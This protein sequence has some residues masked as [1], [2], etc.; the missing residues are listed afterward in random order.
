MNK[1]E[2]I[3]ALAASVSSLPKEDIARSLE[4]YGEMIDER[5]EDG[6]SVDE[7]VD[8][9]GGV[10]EIAGQLLRDEA[11]RGAAF[12][13]AESEKN[14]ARAGESTGVYSLEEPFDSIRIRVAEA[15]VTLTRSGG[16][17]T[18]V[19]TSCDEH[20][21]EIV[22]VRNG[23][24]VIEQKG[25]SQ[26][27]GVGP[28]FGLLRSLSGGGNVTVRL[29]EKN[30]KFI[31]VE[32]L[33]G[34][35]EAEEFSAGR[36]ELSTKNG[37]VRLERAKASAVELSVATGDIGLEDVSAESL[38]ARTYSGDVSLTAVDAGKASLQSTSG[39]LEL[40]DVR[41]GEK[42]A[43]KATS[44][45]VE[46]EGVDAGELEIETVSGDVSGT[47]LS[48]KRVEPHSF[49]GTIRVPP[50]DLSET[51]GLCVIRSVSGDIEI[52]W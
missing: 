16:S 49:S 51:E 2:F 13:R 52:D 33:S 32:T 15:N 24:L 7:A 10:D 46:L 23:V 14:G 44:G 28:I 35:V 4:Y 5:V 11:D 37:D 25:A 36:V 50:A 1:M 12:S 20:I 45:D 8:A 29:A 38:S 22:E 19:N 47:L 42:L 17:E 34:D 40:S 18:L 39:D 9:L 3:A 27:L 21:Q 41:V 43:I 31:T 48:A 30:W 26:R 6:M